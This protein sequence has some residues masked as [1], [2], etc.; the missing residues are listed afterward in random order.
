[1]AF[2]AHSYWE[3]NTLDIKVVAKN[4]NTNGEA[5]YNYTG[6]E[7]G[8]GLSFNN[9]NLFNGWGLSASHSSS[10]I[11]STND[12]TANHHNRNSSLGIKVFVKDNIDFDINLN[13]ESQLN[14]SGITST[15]FLAQ[16]TFQFIQNS[17]NAFVNLNIGN[18]QDHWNVKLSTVVSSSNQSKV[19]T[20]SIFRDDSKYLTDISVAWKVS[21]DSFLTAK[22][23]SQD[24][25]YTQYNTLYSTFIINSY[26]GFKTRYL[27]NSQLSIDLGSSNVIGSD[28]SISWDLTHKTNINDYFIARFSNGRKFS[29]ASDF[30]FDAN[31]NTYCSLNITYI[32][33]S[34]Y[35]VNLSADLT[36]GSIGDSINTKTT[37]LNAGLNLNYSANWSGSAFIQNLVYKDDRGSYDYEQT[38]I[39]FQLSRDLI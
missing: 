13:Q 25:E 3:S 39:G 7:N 14:S 37:S 11:S 38:Q 28:N 32:P 24:N 22:Y 8:I 35:S 16:S 6:V 27:R 18:D 15:N 2:Y 36:D 20:R 34:Y 5:S 23:G 21:E 26:I 33:S 1:M 19:S 30:R 17:S 29:V 12:I 31:L 10:F 9:V 4:L